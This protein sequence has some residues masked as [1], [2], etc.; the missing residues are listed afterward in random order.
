MKE[1]DE[2]K[3]GLSMCALPDG[4]INKCA[5]CQYGAVPGCDQAMKTDALAYIRQL[6]AKLAEYEK[7]LE[8]LT[9][10]EVAANL[11]EKLAS[12]LEEERANHQ[13]TAECAMRLV[14]DLNKSL[15]RESGLHIM[16]TSAQSAA[17]TWERKYKEVLSKLEKA[18][19]ERDALKEDILRAQDKANDMQTELLDNEVHQTCDY[20]LYCALCDALDDVVAWK[21]KELL[22]TTPELSKEET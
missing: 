7:P 14:D 13:Q 21:H 4:P 8:P 17:E 16:L 22:D 19:R 9:P 1:P 10:E 20:G 2:I 3:K 18:T 5:L 6:E 12:Q 15:D 11:I